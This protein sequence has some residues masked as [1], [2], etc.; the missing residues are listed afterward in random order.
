MGQGGLHHWLEV[1]GENMPPREAVYDIIQDNHGFMWFSTGS[2]LYRYDGIRFIR[3][4]SNESVFQVSGYSFSSLVITDDKLWSLADNQKLVCVNTTTLK[5][6][7]F[8]QF[9]LEQEG[10][11][12]TLILSKNNE[13]VVSTTKNKLFWFNVEFNTPSSVKRFFNGKYLIQCMIESQG[14][15]L[16]GTRARGLCSMDKTGKF[17]LSTPVDTFPFPGYSLESIICLN[18]SLILSTGWDNALHFATLSGKPLGYKVFDGSASYSFNGNEGLSS[19]IINDSIVWIG[20]KSNGI[21]SLNIRTGKSETMHGPNFL[22]EHVYSIYKDKDGRIWAGTESGIQLYHAQYDLFK[23]N[24]IPKLQDA[25]LNSRILCLKAFDNKVFIGTNQGLFLEENNTLTHYNLPAQDDQEGIYSMTKFKNDLYL[26]TARTL[27]KFDLEDKKFASG[28]EKFK[29]LDDTYMIDPR[30]VLSSRFYRMESDTQSKSP[31]I[32]A[33]LPGYGIIKYQPDNGKY[34][35]AGV[36]YGKVYAAFVQSIIINNNGEFS[37][38]DRESGLYFNINENSDTLNSIYFNENGDSTQTVKLFRRLFSAKR[39]LDILKYI[40]GD[41]SKITFLEKHKKQVYYLGIKNKGLFL[42]DLSGKPKLKKIAIQ[43]DN[44]Q[45][46]RE[47]VYGRLWISGNGKLWLYHPENN[48]L[49]QFGQVYGLSADGFTTGF[50]ENEQGEIVIASYNE[51]YRFNPHEITLKQVFVPLKLT[52]ASSIERQSIELQNSG[53]IEIHESENGL[54]F[55]FA[56]L[57]YSDPSS[58][59]YAYTIE[60]YQN[61]W[62][63][64]NNNPSFQISKMPPGDYLLRINAFDFNGEIIANQLIIPIHVQ[65]YW[66]NTI[67]FRIGVILIILITIYL[68]YKYRLNQILKLQKVRDQIARDLHDDIGS[69]L[70][71]INLYA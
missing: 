28:L 23:V 49:E 69:T 43:I 27:Y 60:G 57:E 13:L 30:A 42:I 17:Q 3:F 21:F 1:K 56:A 14:K 37:V 22:G 33:A 53:N 12:L 50:S 63:K 61:K 71:A 58:V 70:G 16:L 7:L 48:N 44:P 11:P 39:Y 35:S 25:D 36:F 34:I 5:S 24:T 8:Y 15:I 38:A 47:D 51:W 9:D 29:E 55:E 59:Q 67:A 54:K 41:R 40:P 46:I 2:G 64:L 26:G 62:I 65:P 10:G 68:I 20:S 6:D 32:I 52:R 45:A 4:H 31:G 66:F 19:E 18:D